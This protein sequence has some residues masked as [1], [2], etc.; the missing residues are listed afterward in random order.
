M[1]EVSL[2][3]GKHGISIPKMNEDYS[4]K[5]LKRNRS[6][7]SYL[8]NFRVEVFYVVIDLALQ[9]LNNHFDVMT[10]DL[11]LGMASLSLVDSFANFHKDRIMK[12]AEYYPRNQGSCK[13]DD[14]DKTRS[15]LVICVS[16]SEANFDYSCC[17]RKRGNNIIINEV[18]KK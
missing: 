16:T 7:I 6:N 13:S 3:C 8:H 11:L 14:R 17:Y 5:K 18:H 10:S 12:L 9:E 15:N 1:D 4:N 2:F